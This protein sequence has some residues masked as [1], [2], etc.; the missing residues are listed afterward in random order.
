MQWFQRGSSRAVHQCWLEVSAAVGGLLRGRRQPGYGADWR[1][2]ESVLWLSICA[3]SVLPGAGLWAADTYSASGAIWE[4]WRCSVEEWL[5]IGL[6]RES[7]F[8]GGILLRGV[9][10]QGL[11]AAHGGA[12][13]TAA[14]VTY[15]GTRNVAQ[16]A[17]ITTCW[18]RKYRNTLFSE[19]II[20]HLEE[21]QLIPLRKVWRWCVE[22]SGRY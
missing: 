20:S 22:V 9:G 13:W 21:S 11:H 15:A 4:L 2:A 1:Q 5:V 16:K 3:P 8:C 10:G 18:M 12:A 14:S 19:K 7:C 6:S 17:L